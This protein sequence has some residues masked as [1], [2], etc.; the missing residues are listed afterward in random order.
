MSNDF[1]LLD[2]LE[3]GY[4]HMQDLQLV[5]Y[6]DLPSNDAPCIDYEAHSY[7]KGRPMLIQ[8]YN[9]LFLPRLP[10]V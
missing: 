3:I 7:S 9:L 4:N 1:N 5:S 8:F 2:N 6:K 10:S